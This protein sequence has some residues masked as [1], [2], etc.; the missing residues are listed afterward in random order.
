[1]KRV[2]HALIAAITCLTAVTLS[3]VAEDASPVGAMAPSDKRVML[4]TDSVGLGARGAFANAFP[5]DWDAVVVGQPARFVEQ[6]ES[7]FVRP[8]LFRAGDHVVIAG[9]Y[10]YPYWDPERFERSV[11]S[12]INTLT[13]A[14]VSTCTGSRCVK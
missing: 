10:N 4:V 12:I 6:L 7:N 5:S 11:D 3:T 14:G 2:G 8:N 1:M 9:G 13:G